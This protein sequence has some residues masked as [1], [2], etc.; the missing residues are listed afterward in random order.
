M[1][2]QKWMTNKPI[3]AHLLPSTGYNDDFMYFL[4]LHKCLFT[5]VYFGHP[6]K[7][8]IQIGSFWSFKVL[9]TVCLKVI[10]NCLNCS[11]KRLYK[12]WNE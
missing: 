7:K 8:N 2:K 11:L 12:P 9:E 3:S 6:I 10:E 4:I 1:K 5:T